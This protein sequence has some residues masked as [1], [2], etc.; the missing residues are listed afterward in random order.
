MSE[1]LPH[2]ILVKPS[3]AKSWSL[4][5]RRVWFDNHPPD[6]LEIEIG[7][8]DQLVIDL[9]LAHEKFI[10]EQLSQ[11][12]EVHEALSVEHTIELVKQGVD[13]IYQAQLMDEEE[14]FIGFPDFL[15]RHE[16]G[17]YQAA[18]AKL[19]LSEDKK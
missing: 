18:D 4:C 8:F 10:L 3:D 17:Q 7:E 15:F 13:V 6:G 12:F 5:A 1:N 11:D 2:S 9:G 19:S 14:R 16:S